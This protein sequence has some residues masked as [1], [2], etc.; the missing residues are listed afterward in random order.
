VFAGLCKVPVTDEVEDRASGA[1][2]GGSSAMLGSRPK[3]TG[4]VKMD[5]PLV[6]LRAGHSSSVCLRQ[7]P[8]GSDFSGVFLSPETPDEF[9]WQ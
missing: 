6:F 4:Q 3:G 5:F 7:S 2:K 1:P 9:T 8:E